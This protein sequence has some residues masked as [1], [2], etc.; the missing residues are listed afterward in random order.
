[1]DAVG[2]RL[3]PSATVKDLSRSAHSTSTL[4]QLRHTPTAAS[5]DGLEGAAIADEADEAEVPRRARLKQVTGNAKEGLKDFFSDWFGARRLQHEESLGPKAE[6]VSVLGKAE[7]KSQRRA[8]FQVVK[9]RRKRGPPTSR[10]QVADYRDA[11]QRELKGVGWGGPPIKR[12]KIK[13]NKDVTKA[14][15][16]QLDFTGQEEEEHESLADMLEGQVHEEDT[17]F[18]VMQSFP[19]FTLIQSVLIFLS[20]LVLAVA[21]GTS[22]AGLETFFPGQT[23]LALAGPGCQDLR[24]QLWRPITYQFSHSSFTHMLGN[25]LLLVMCGINL[26]GFHGS[27]RLFWMFEIGVL[28]GAGCV[29]VFDSH[30]RVLGMS[31]GGYALL[32]M[33]LGDVLLNWERKSAVY[34]LIFIFLLALVEVM[35]YFLNPQEEISY[36]AHAGGGVAGLLLVLVFGRNL[37]VKTYDC[38]TQV[39]RVAKVLLAGLAIFCI[40]WALIHWPPMSLLEQVPYCWAAQVSNE[41]FFG[42][43]DLHC[44]RCDGAAC[45]ARW[46]APLQ[47]ESR[48][49]SPGSC[50]SWAVTER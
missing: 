2:L 11:T 17:E 48:V 3:P 27:L 50:R 42:D 10:T 18:F 26:E 1:M 21:S 44:V 37:S 25:V 40:C 13:D 31:G 30:A 28:G 19:T 34:R 32:G 23:D 22:P 12:P 43:T 36:S 38:E 14:Q 35:L 4:D 47:N 6:Q 24:F 46:S 9:G 5:F 39:I 33:Q 8:N 7:D 49:V 29:Y 45:I 16:M 15:Q 41:T 20:Y